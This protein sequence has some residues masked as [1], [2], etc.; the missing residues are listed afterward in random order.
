MRKNSII[1]QGG[2]I[3]TTAKLAAIKLQSKLIYIHTIGA[4]EAAKNVPPFSGFVSFLF[5]PGFKTY[6]RVQVKL[7]HGVLTLLTPAAE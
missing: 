3:I 6:F 2:C 1:F 7:T 4:L 5:A